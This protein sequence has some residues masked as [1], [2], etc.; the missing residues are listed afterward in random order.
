MS[1]KPATLVT[2]PISAIELRVTTM[3]AGRQSDGTV[4][5]YY[6]NN[7]WTPTTGGNSNLAVIAIEA[8]VEHDLTDR[9]MNVSDTFDFSEKSSLYPIGTITTNTGEIALSNEDGIFNPENTSSPYAGLIE[10]NCE[11]NLEYIFT[12]D[13]T[14]YA[15]QQ[16]KM[17]AA[18]WSSSEGTTTVDLEDYSKYLKEIKLSYKTARLYCLKRGRFSNR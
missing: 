12:I 18:N 13:G 7:V 2:T 6:K 8:H 5:G 16:F 15:V 14:D 11:V 10:P 9:L 3:E 17:Y 1:T 4:T